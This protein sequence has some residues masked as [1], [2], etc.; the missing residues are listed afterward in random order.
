[1][2]EVRRMDDEVKK[3][4]TEEWTDRQREFY[5]CLSKVIENGTYTETMNWLI[6][7][8]WKAENP[9]ITLSWTPTCQCEGNDGSGK[10]IVLDPFAGSCTTG[11][12]AKKLGRSYVMIDPNPDYCVM[13]EK[14]IADTDEPGPESQA[15]QLELW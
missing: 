14:R 10:C 9:D 13:G 5:H 11:A 6:Y 15:V 2:M 4:F 3:D 7:S 1:M 8:W 12:V